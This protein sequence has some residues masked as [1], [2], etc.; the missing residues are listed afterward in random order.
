MW[1]SSRRRRKG[2]SSRAPSSCLPATSPMAG[3]REMAASVCWC[4]QKAGAGPIPWPWLSSGDLS[5]GNRCFLGS[6]AYPRGTGM[7]SGPLSQSSPPAHSSSSQ[8]RSSGF[9]LSEKTVRSILAGDG[10]CRGARPAPHS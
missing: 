3:S 2:P 1:L 4:F 6:R 10:T 7:A 9:P 5:L 8:M